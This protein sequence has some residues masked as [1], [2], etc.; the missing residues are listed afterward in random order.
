V[1]PDGRF[2][3]ASNAGTSSI[4]GFKIGTDGSLTALPGTVVGTNPAGS[5]NLD[6]TISADGSSIESGRIQH[7]SGDDTID[8]DLTVQLGRLTESHEA[9]PDLSDE[10]R[11]S[12]AGHRYRVNYQPR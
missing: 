11:T 3:Y 8:G 10:E 12:I 2:V 5:A 9:I 1:T 4:S 7:G 6:I